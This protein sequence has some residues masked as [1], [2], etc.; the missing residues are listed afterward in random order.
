MSRNST[1]IATFCECEALAKELGYDLEVDPAG[2]I[3]LARNG[4]MLSATGVY[5]DHNIDLLKAWLEGARAE[6]KR[7][8][9]ENNE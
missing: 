4:K 6:R 3:T 9:K 1:I 2:A 7:H 5:H 8:G